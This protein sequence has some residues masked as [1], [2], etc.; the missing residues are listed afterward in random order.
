[1]ST[2]EDALLKR[3]AEVHALLQAPCDPAATNALR[4]EL[5]KIKTSL[6]SLRHRDDP[7][8]KQ[9]AYRMRRLRKLRACLECLAPLP[10]DQLVNQTRTA[11]HMKRVIAAKLNRYAPT[12]KCESPCLLSDGTPCPP[13]TQES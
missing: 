9:R 13:A 5:R 10:N 6:F 12:P 7:G 3:R 8:R 4:K 11:G 1:M 2:T